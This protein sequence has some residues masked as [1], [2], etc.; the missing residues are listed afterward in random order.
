MVFAVTPRM[1]AGQVLHHCSEMSSLLALA[2]A[3]EKVW[4]RVA[5]PGWLL[6]GF[7]PSVPRKGDSWVWRLKHPK[8][9]G[10]SCV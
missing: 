8:S 10:I 3:L 2:L 4:P 1:L 5:G 9:Y 7:Q 6:S